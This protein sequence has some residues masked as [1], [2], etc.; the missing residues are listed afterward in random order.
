MPI[1]IPSD[2]TLRVDANA[3]GSLTLHFRKRPLEAE[4]TATEATEVADADMTAAVADI[5]ATT[6]TLKRH[7][8]AVFDEKLTLAKSLVATQGNDAGTMALVRMFVARCEEKQGDDLLEAHRKFFFTIS[9]QRGSVLSIAQ[10]LDVAFPMIKMGKQASLKALNGR[11]VALQAKK[12]QGKQQAGQLAIRDAQQMSTALYDAARAVLTDPTDETAVPCEDLLRFSLQLRMN[13]GCPHTARDDGGRLSMDDFVV[14]DRICTFKAGSK[15]HDDKPRAEYD[16]ICLFDDETTTGLHTH[17]FFDGRKG[18]G[19]ERKAVLSRTQLE[20]HGMMP[21][22]TDVDKYTR[23]KWRGIGAS[24]LRT[25]S[26]IATGGFIWTMIPAARVVNEF[27]ICF[28][29]WGL[30]LAAE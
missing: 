22:I 5:D 14:Q 24:F 8:T 23:V 1:H 2:A 30:A 15:S 12:M 13:E 20:N 25:F 29:A 4:T 10:M 18:V 16:K 17:I 11:K 3:D 26:R 7:K 27:R 9:S 28:W 6:F 21:F 19:N